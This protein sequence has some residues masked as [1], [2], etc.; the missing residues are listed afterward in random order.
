MQWVCES[1]YVYMYPS[2]F[3]CCT[4]TFIS[5]PH[6]HGVC[7]SNR[8]RIEM[9]MFSV[10]GDNRTYDDWDADMIY[11]CNCDDGWQGVS[12]DKRSCPH[13]D[14]PITDGVSEVQVIDCE[15]DNNIGSVVLTF[16]IES[17]RPIPFNTT[18]YIVK[19]ELERLK[20][21]TEVTVTTRRGSGL[22]SHSGSVTEITF[23]VPQKPPY[24]LVA[25]KHNEFAG[26]INVKSGGAPSQIDA[27]ITSV[28]STREYA[29]CSNRGKNHSVLHMNLLFHR[30][31]DDDDDDDDSVFTHFK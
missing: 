27:S 19:Y 22:C 2:S 28:T 17:T 11:G 14:D 30:Y 5:M 23:L 16:G 24:V 15:T 25:N 13:G 3:Y 6:R 9:N 4:H 21:I 18:E 12:C 31:D 20:A 10:G 26:F 7:L 29:E 1:I 8:D